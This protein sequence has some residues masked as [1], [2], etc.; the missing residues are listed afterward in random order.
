CPITEACPI[1]KDIKTK[2]AN[3]MI[4][5][6]LA[7]FLGVNTGDSGLCKSTD[8]RLILIGEYALK[9]LP[10]FDKPCLIFP[11]VGLAAYMEKN[12]LCL[13]LRASSFTCD[14]VR[15]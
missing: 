6:F 2:K 4:T 7:N 3:V 15:G 8:G 14:M 10:T 11:V 9:Y 1:S 12:F 5:M 13:V